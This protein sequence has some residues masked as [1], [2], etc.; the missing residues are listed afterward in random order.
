[1]LWVREVATS[2]ASPVPASQAE[3]ASSSTGEMVIDGSCVVRANIVRARYRAN[4]IASIHNRAD[5][6]CVRCIESPIIPRI[7]AEEKVK[8]AGVM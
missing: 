8:C 1:M 7:K 3:N 5:T 4:I 6:K 2:R